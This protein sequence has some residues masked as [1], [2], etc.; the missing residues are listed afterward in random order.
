VA[1]AT[2]PETAQ[3]AA[4]ASALRAIELADRQGLATLAATRGTARYA[5]AVNALVTALSSE[6]ALMGRLAAAA[7]RNDRSRYAY[8]RMQASSLY[9]RLLA[10]I[11]SLSE[12]GY[13][14]AKPRVATIPWVP[15]RAAVRPVHAVVVARSKLPPAITEAP[16]GRTEVP[17]ENH[18]TVKTKPQN[19]PPAQEEEFVTAPK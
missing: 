5:A 18:P 7:Q 8:L 10:A 17:I 19:K 11:G 13:Q 15:P 1:Q 2:V 16:P 3:L 12:R 6:A 14:M 9:K 4:R